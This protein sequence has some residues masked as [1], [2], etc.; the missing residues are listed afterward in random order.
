MVVG[1]M[2]L[3]YAF[4][5]AIITNPVTM[6]RQLAWFLTL[7]GI[8]VALYFLAT[9]DWNQYPGKIAGLTVMGQHLQARLPF[10]EWS[11]RGKQ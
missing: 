9:N 4:A 8:A 10:S 11:P 2:L 6:P 3:Y 7:S 5:N 1:S